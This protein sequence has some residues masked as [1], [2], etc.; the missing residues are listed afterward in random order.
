MK[1]F[2]N[3][4]LSNITSGDFY[5]TELVL[6]QS[7]YC[8]EVFTTKRDDGYGPY[9]VGIIINE[10]N[11]KPIKFLIDL[12]DYHYDETFL[13]IN[14]KIN[15]LPRSNGPRLKPL[16]QQSEEI[17]KL[18]TEF[19]NSKEHKIENKNCEEKIS[20]S[21]YNLSSSKKDYSEE[22]DQDNSSNILDNL[23]ITATQRSHDLGLP[24]FMGVCVPSSKNIKK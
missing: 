13:I 23:I 3:E 15:I 8:T 11:D 2:F 14:R 22:I 10:K 7:G 20:K 21:P 12:N 17:I 6:L 5:Q 16:D 1:T 19:R 9:L 4:D 24:M 18:I